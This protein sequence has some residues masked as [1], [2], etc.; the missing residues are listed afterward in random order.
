MISTPLSFFVTG[1]DTEVGKTTI[2]SALLQLAKQQ[3]LSTLGLKPIASGCQQEKGQWV[4]DDAL[5]LMK[6]SSISV[7]YSD[8]NPIALEPAIAPHIAAEQAGV[9][10]D[11]G[12]LYQHSLRMQKQA[13]DLLLMEGAG[14]WLLPLNEQQTLADLCVMLKIPVILV[15][16]MKLG[17][18]NHALLTSHVIR[19]SGLRLAGWVAN[20]M[21]PQM[22]AYDENI[23]TLVQRLPAPCLG[24]IPHAKSNPFQTAMAHLD[25]EPLIHA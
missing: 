2:T 13:A 22:E 3:G 11:L 1:T 20:Q 4:N 14:G 7:P 18:L 9:T 16:G 8:I 17:C 21:V 10:V 25:L 6:A 15:V 24:K 23:K 12:E 5:Q 19:Q